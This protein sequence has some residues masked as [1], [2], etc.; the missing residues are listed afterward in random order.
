MYGSEMGF[1]PCPLCLTSVVVSKRSWREVVAVDDVDV[2]DMW[3]AGR[4]FLFFRICNDAAAC[5]LSLV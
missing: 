3:E 4:A 5:T 1:I 2:D